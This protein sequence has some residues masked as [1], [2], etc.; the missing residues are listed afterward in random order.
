MGKPR[1]YTNDEFIEAVKC[2][3]SIRQLLHR[4]NLKEAGGN[5]SICKKRIADLKIDI[6][7]FGSIKERQ[8]WAKGKKFQGRYVYSLEEVLVEGS[9]FQSY[10]LKKRLLE[11]GIFKHVCL[12]CK[13]EKW[14]EKPIPLELDHIN[15]NNKDNRIENLRLLCHNCDSTTTT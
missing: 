15:G 9:S 14:L 1:K 2:S 10:K 7:H 8:G 6:S 5:Y 12:I 11:A 3:Q 13:L 4:L